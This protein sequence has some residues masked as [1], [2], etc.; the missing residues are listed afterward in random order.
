[1][2]KL[3]VLTE[4]DKVKSVDPK[5]MVSITDFNRHV[6]ESIYK[7]DVVTYLNKQGKFEVIKSRIPHK[8]VLNFLKTQIKNDEH[9]N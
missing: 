3:L 5:T 8:T 1:M 2:I 4:Q 9:K 6:K 7:S